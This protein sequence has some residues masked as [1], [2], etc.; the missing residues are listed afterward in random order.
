MKLH[1]P[2]FLFFVA[3]SIFSS[4]QITADKKSGCAPFTVSFSSPIEGNWDFGNGTSAILEY[5]PSATFGYPGIYTVT[6]TDIIGDTI[7][8]DTIT[9]F[10]NPT[11]DFNADETSGCAPFS[12]TFNDTSTA[13]GTSKI[14]KWDWAFIGTSTG[15]TDK[16]P[17]KTFSSA[18]ES[19]VILIVEDDNGCVDDTIK[20]DFIS[21]INPP[22]ASFTT[23]TLTSCSAPLNVTLTNTSTNSDGGTTRLNY[24]WDF[25]ETET[26]TDENPG[27]YTFDSIGNYTISLTVSEEGGCS[28]SQLKTVNI[29]QP[30]AIIYVQDTVC[31]GSSTLYSNR[32]KGGTSFKWIFDD[33]ETSTSDSLNKT[34][35]T[36]GSHEVTLIAIDLGCNDTTAKTIFVQQAEVTLTGS[37]SK[38]CDEPFCVQFSASGDEIENWNY[39]FFGGKSSTEQNPEHCY[40]HI[41]GDEYTVHD[42]KGY[43][44]NTTV[45]GTTYYGCSASANFRDTIFPLSANFAPNITQ[46]CAP[47]SVNFQ[48]SSASG[49]PIISYKY[50]FDDGSIGFSDSVNHVFSIAGEYDVTLVIE[51]ENGCKDTSF[52]IQVQVGNSIDIDLLVSPSIVCIGDTVIITD[53]TGDPRIDEYHFSTDENRGSESCPGD[54]IQQW[55]YFHETGQHDITFYANYNGCLS[56]KVF[57]DAVKVTGPSSYFKWSGNCSSPTEINFEA[58]VSEVDSLY[59]YFGDDKTLATSDLADT[60]VT[61]TYDT[62]GNYTV[63]LISTNNSTGC[64]NDTNTMLIKVRLLE[65]VIEI[66]SL[67][68]SGSNFIAS[69][70]KSVE[71]S[72]DC[73]NAYRWDKGDSTKM[74][75]S[76]SPTW[77]TSLSDTGQH[78][79]RLMVYDVNGCR[80]TTEKT[81][82][83]TDLYAGFTT[84]VKTGCLPLTIKFTDTSRSATKLETWAWD[85]NDG[86]TGTDSVE[87]NTYT[88]SNISHYDVVLKV[89]DSLG[90]SDEAIFKISP[91]IPDSTFKVNDE[92]I[93]IGDSVTFTLDDHESMSNA[94]WSFGNQGTS[95]QINAGFQFDT[96]GDYTINVQLTDTNGCQTEKTENKFILVDGYPIA[97]YFSDKDDQDIICYPAIIKFTDTSKI[98]FGVTSFGARYW[99][100]DDTPITTSATS[101]TLP[102]LKPGNHSIRLIE[103]SLNGCRDS[104][105]K[106]VTVSGPEGKIDSIIS[107][108]CIG[109]KVTLDIKDSSDVFALYWTFGTEGAV[110]DTI[111]ISSGSS[112]ETSYRIN[113]VPL[114]G[115]TK[116]QMTLFSEDFKCEAYAEIDI[117]VHQIKAAFSFE[118]STVCLDVKAVFEDNSLSTASTAYSWDMGNGST[119]DYVTNNAPKPE[120]YS[121]TGNY[122]IRLMINDPVSGCLDTVEE[123]LIILPPPNVS[124]IN[125]KIC[126]GD[127]ALLEAYG[128]ETY[129]W[130]DTNSTVVDIN[131]DST[132]AYPDESINYRVFGTD[133]N[134]CID[135]AL[136]NVALLQEKE[137]I[138][139][140]TCVIIGDSVTIGIDYGPGFTYDWSE[141]PT[142]FLECLKCPVQTIQITEEVDSI[143]YELAYSDSLNCFP[144]VN[145]YNVCV[146]DRYTVDVPSAFTPDGS[147]D[148]DIIYIN[149]HGIKELIYFRIYNRWGEI[150]FETTDIDKGWNGAYKGAEQGIETF[151]YQAKVKF[152]NNEF[153]VKGGDI[154]LIR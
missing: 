86:N 29:G 112:V 144:K 48:D 96:A 31:I 5:N 99:E 71:V 128:A 145:E 65:A 66:D 24:Y 69:G 85:F 46:G 105:T 102:F 91:I 52:P 13:K 151:V 124:T 36:S 108:I 74:F 126:F 6:L 72:G 98:N 49:S 104:L 27:I 133:T 92:E 16:N 127:P 3:Q 63:I 20:T 110:S 113:D 146:E 93:C 75:L 10:E 134:G 56:E 129:L 55:S 88:Q 142:Q 120:R 37:P 34:F 47:L 90:C 30:E 25:G 15:S 114:S 135:S 41:G 89:T 137:F 28:D 122:N 106:P 1:I 125:K 18:G 131:S 100:L 33:G 51:N 12:T 42:Y 80:D 153:K 101:V 140:D 109:E 11:A 60:T 103:E 54:S 154:T 35:N 32:S 136:A 87:S 50:H 62:S 17:T 94:F 45:T 132:L 121:S 76:S 4:A 53:A 77:S 26:S 116:A 79:I 9:V 19:T 64:E 150:V 59:W 61:H 81:I 95:T 43:N 7:D 67:I 39:A 58:T 44:Y 70:E 143:L 68:C 40:E 107:T 97:G 111:I 117:N 152:Y 149:G 130:I 119:Y 78:I 138:R 141:G 38:Q 73:E 83:I 14:I 23:T 2:L 147:G 148:N 82:V 139:E 22:N 84:D 118:D 115:S 21:V 57:A 123:N 8:Q